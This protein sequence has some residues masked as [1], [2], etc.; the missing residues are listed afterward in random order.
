MTFWAID[1]VVPVVDPTAFVHPQ[2]SVIGDVRIGADCYV[3]PGASLRGDFG[4]IEVGAGSNVQDG[5]VVHAYPGAAAVLSEG[6]HVGHAAVLHGCHLEPRVLVG[7]GAVVLDGARI[8][9]GSLVGAGSVVRAGEHFPERS[10]LVGNP[11]RRVR[12]VDDEMAA[13]KDNGLRVYG[14]LTRRSRAGLVEVD[15]LQEP[16]AGRPVLPVDASTATPLHTHP[17]RRGTRS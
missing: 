12:D 3:G 2:A 10:L 15:P 16:E 4:L 14:E 13:W 5:C 6:S 8:G 11:A 9:A 17:G 7:I 1:G